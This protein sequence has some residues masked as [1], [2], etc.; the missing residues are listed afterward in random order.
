VLPVH[1]APF[2]PKSDCETYCALLDSTCLDENVSEQ[3]RGHRECLAV[4]E[5]KAP[6]GK[7]DESGDTMGCRLKQARAA[8]TPAA[9]KKAT[10]C[11]SAGPLGGGVC[12]SVCEGYCAIAVPVC[13]GA[14]AE[15]SGYA[16]WPECM[17]ACSTMTNRPTPYHRG[18]DMYYGSSVQCRT[19]HAANEADDIY[20]SDGKQTSFFHCAQARAIPLNTCL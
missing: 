4:C 20:A 11:A 5:L 16:N 14:P 18:G 12:G 2:D 8:A 15:R 10:L 9:D 13:Q 1:G 3:Y 7:G 6:G 17:A 19:A